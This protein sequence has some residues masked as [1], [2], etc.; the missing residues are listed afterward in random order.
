VALADAGGVPDDGRFHGTVIDEALTK[1][2]QA[3]PAWL[4]ANKSL[5]DSL[6]SG[7]LKFTDDEFIR[8]TGWPPVKNPFYHAA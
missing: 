7:E 8:V 3:L 6:V 5:L 1:A 4:E 2:N